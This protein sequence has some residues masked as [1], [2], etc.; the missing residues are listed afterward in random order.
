[1]RIPEMRKDWCYHIVVTQWLRELTILNA[2]TRTP[3]SLLRLYPALPWSPKIGEQ[4]IVDLSMSEISGFADVSDLFGTPFPAPIFALLFGLGEIGR[5]FQVGVIY[6]WRIRAYVYR[7]RMYLRMDSSRLFKRTLSTKWV[8]ST[9]Y[10]AVMLF[11]IWYASR[12]M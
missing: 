12:L 1:M 9:P 6:P 3:P 11:S 5:I 4:C 2:N 7:S 8:L 10:T